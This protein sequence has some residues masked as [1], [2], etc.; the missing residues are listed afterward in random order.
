MIIEEV[1]SPRTSRSASCSSSSSSSSQKDKDIKDTTKKLL[2]QH[3]LKPQ[4][5][6]EDAAPDTRRPIRVPSREIFNSFLEK[7]YKDIITE[8]LKIKYASYLVYFP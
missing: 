3:K 5:T 7:H 1:P 6:N 4:K 2:I 8:A